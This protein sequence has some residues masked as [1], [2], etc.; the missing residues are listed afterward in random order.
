MCRE[1]TACCA[2]GD[3]GHSKLRELVAGAE[4]CIGARFRLLGRGP[5]AYDCLGV[6]MA[7]AARAGLRLNVPRGYDPRWVDPAGVR[8]VLVENGFVKIASPTP[9]DLVWISAGGRQ[10]FQL[11]TG[12]GVIEAD[13]G[14]RLVVRRPAAMPDAAWRFPEGD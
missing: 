8:R 1:P 4:A 14:L 9:G 7:A 5:D 10:H 13:A 2:V 6:M 3:A 12:A 11:W